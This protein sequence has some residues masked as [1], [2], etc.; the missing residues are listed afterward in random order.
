MTLREALESIYDRHGALTPA[1]VVEEA[2]DPEDE[3]ARFIR[4]RLTWDDEEAGDR[5]RLIE[6][7]RLIRK[8]R[9]VYKSTPGSDL[10][11]IREYVSVQM[12]DGRP[13]SYQPLEKV[14]QDP[15]VA[16]IML[17]EAERAFKD[18]QSRYGQLAGFVA[19]VQKTLL[20]VP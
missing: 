9:V 1:I 8:C 13:R 5:Y 20:G 14:A 11:S 3:A 12:L 10:R 18:L 19:M 16:A 6:A 15:L 17:A 2:R 4:T 7:A